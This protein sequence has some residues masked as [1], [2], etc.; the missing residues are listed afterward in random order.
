M[1]FKL[2]CIEHVSPASFRTVVNLI[3]VFLYNCF[4][5]SSFLYIYLFAS[6]CPQL[7][8]SVKIGCSD[9]FCFASVFRNVS[10]LTLVLSIL[11]AQHYI[12]VHVINHTGPRNFTF[13]RRMDLKTFH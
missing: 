13:F 8:L 7:T 10:F 4:R 11:M 5:F 6:T 3:S 9:N 12:L 1:F 2:F